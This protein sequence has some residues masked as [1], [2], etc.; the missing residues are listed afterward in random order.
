M[1]AARPSKMIA[2]VGGGRLSRELPPTVLR[3]DQEGSIELRL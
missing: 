1:A 2:S 3:T